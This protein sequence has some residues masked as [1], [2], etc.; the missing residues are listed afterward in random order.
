M[1]TEIEI[2]TERLSLLTV[3]RAVER[4][5]YCPDLVDGDDLEMT[6]D[7]ARQLVSAIKTESAGVNNN[8]IAQAECL[9]KEIKNC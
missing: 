4:L 6:L 1:K 7:F 5:I 3:Q 8:A 9:L 2:P